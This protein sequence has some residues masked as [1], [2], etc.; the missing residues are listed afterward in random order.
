MEYY[1]CALQLIHT[2]R[3]HSVCHANEGSIASVNQGLLLTTREE[4]RGMRP[5]LRRGDRQN[6]DYEG[7]ISPPHKKASHK[8]QS[9]NE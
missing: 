7:T 6:V 8:K 2:A 5:L 4:K 9:T 1:Y 3:Q